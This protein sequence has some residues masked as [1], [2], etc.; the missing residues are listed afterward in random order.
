[1]NTLTTTGL[2]EITQTHKQLNAQLQSVA[3]MGDYFDGYSTHSIFVALEKSCKDGIAQCERIMRLVID[4]TSEMEPTCP[5]LEWLDKMADDDDDPDK[6]DRGLM[7]AAIRS[8]DIVVSD[9][10]LIAMRRVY[11]SR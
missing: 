7:I 9:D 3:T 10:V 4:A 1:M 11:H 5:G 2:S 8:G 6:E